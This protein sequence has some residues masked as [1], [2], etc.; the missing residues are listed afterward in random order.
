MCAS[1]ESTLAWFYLSLL[2]NIIVIPTAI[3]LQNSE[4]I[5]MKALWIV[6]ELV[7]DIDLCNCHW[8]IDC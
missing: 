1:M 7:S 8:H 2:N 4:K 3:T 6:V 5:V